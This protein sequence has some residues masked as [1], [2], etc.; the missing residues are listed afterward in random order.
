MRSGDIP[1]KFDVTDLS[2]SAGRGSYGDSE[3]L[4]R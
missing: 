4:F 1:F 2:E 3:S